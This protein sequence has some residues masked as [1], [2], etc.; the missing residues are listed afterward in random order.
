MKVL[1]NIVLLC[2]VMLAVCGCNKEDIAMLTLDRTTL[3]FSSWKSPSQ[4]IRYTSDNTSDIIVRSI[5]EGWSALPNHAERTITVTATGSDKVED[6]NDMSTGSMI[7]DAVTPKGETTTYYVTL[8]VLGKEVEVLD[9]AGM[10]NCYVVSEGRKCYTFD[11]SHRPDG[12]PLATA[13]VKLLWDSESYIVQN[14]NFVDGK[15]EFYIE[16]EEPTTS[17]VVNVN[18]VLAAYDSSDKIIWSWHLWIV[19]DNPLKA[20]ADP[21]SGVTFMDRNLG[22]YKGNN[23]ASQD[24]SA[25]HSAYGLYYQWGRKDPFARPYAYD[26][27]GADDETL[28]GSSA[29]YIYSTTKEVSSSVGTVE[30]ATANPMAYI[31]NAACIEENGNGIGDWMYSANDKL[32]NDEAKSLYDPCPYGW[33]VPRASELATLTFASDNTSDLDTARKQYGWYLENASERYFFSGCGYRRYT[34]GKIQNVNYSDVYPYNP[35]P[36][37]GHY[38]SSTANSDGSAVSLYFD[39]ITTRSLSHYAANK[40]SRRANGMQVRCIKE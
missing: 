17:R 38:W 8:Y 36:W 19:N 29:G 12:S 14:I 3:Y 13:K 37:E 10:A 39:L 11:A 15:A 31:T 30:Y 35:E 16:S 28:Y 25:V 26:A 34:D 20:V 21:K 7:I 33:R 40:A 32:W 2:S 22:A 18:A 6:D 1:R 23:S 5:S 4:T 27:S 9:E 24:H